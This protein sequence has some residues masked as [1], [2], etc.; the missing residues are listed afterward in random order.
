MNIIKEQLMKPL[1][2]ENKGNVVFQTNKKFNFDFRNF[3]R[4]LNSLQN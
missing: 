4:E 1:V 3:E 2:D